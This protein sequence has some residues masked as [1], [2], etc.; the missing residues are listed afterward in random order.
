MDGI[1]SG[2]ALFAGIPADQLTE[3]LQCLGEI[4]K[5]FARGCT[6]FQAGTVP[7]QLGLVLK[8]RVLVQ[9]CDAW[10][11]LSVLGSAS[12]G[13][14]F[15]EAYA[16]CPGEPLQISVQAAEDTTALFLNASR[17]LTVCPASC[18]FHA[19]LVRNLLE[20]CAR[21]NLML[22]RRMLHI[23]PK[24]IR[25]RLLSYFSQCARQAKSPVFTLE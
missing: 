23:T 14:T 24:T 16:C 20:V 18:P 1:L 19:R 8:G 9:C 5:Q 11:N 25:G 6:I 4:E 22:S 3:L 15:G 10:G 21:K 2:S 17:V 12:P 7:D 13:E